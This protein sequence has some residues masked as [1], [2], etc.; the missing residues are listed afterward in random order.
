M[1]YAPVPYHTVHDRARGLTEGYKMADESTMDATNGADDGR[2]QMLTAV[3]GALTFGVLIGSIAAARGQAVFGSVLWLLLNRIVAICVF[4]VIAAMGRRRV[5]VVRPGAVFPI[6]AVCFGVHAVAVL[7]A[8]LGVTGFELVA[9]GVVSVMFEGAFI[10][11]VELCVVSALRRYDLLIAS[12]SIAVAFLINNLYDLLFIDV[13]PSIALAQWLVGGV[14]A[15]VGLGLLVRFGALE[16]SVP[17]DTA[18]TVEGDGTGVRE[19]AIG[20]SIVRDSFVAFAVYCTMLMLFRG[21][22]TGVTGLGGIGESS[23]FGASTDIL[24]LVVRCLLIV[25]CVVAVGRVGKTAT[26]LLT[27]VMW[28]LAATVMVACW[29]GDAARFGDWIMLA[30]YYV[31]QVMV[32]VAAIEAAQRH[33][34][35]SRS[36]LACGLIVFNAN[37]VTRFAGYLAFGGYAAFDVR[38][39]AALLLVSVTALIVCAAMAVIA[40]TRHRTF[41]EAGDGRDVSRERELAH[42]D[43]G[44]SL[45]DQDPLLVY[46]RAFC[47]SFVRVCDRTGVPKR[48]RQ[49][50]FM[51]AHGYTIEGTASRLGLSRETVKTEL[52]R[53]YARTGTGGKQAFLAMVDDGVSVAV[54]EVFSQPE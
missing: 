34:A 35:Q 46:E 11:L 25:W 4:V 41:G 37:H 21:V 53:A 3:V 13:S 10:A 44:A 32:I 31:I 1:S 39:A 2:G 22:F 8:G 43:D 19:P 50:L 54:P 47:E 26:V 52:A 5:A 9:L 30:A 42:V 7:C 40:D 17:D 18:I 38:D 14:L 16:P 51:A 20:S 49:V 15:L 6:A 28:A 33:C 27:L 45:S 23:Y 24:M 36:L 48:E 29:N 12:V